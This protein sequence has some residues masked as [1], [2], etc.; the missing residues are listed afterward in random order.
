MAISHVHH[1]FRDKVQFFTGHHLDP[2][3]VVGITEI[4][5]GLVKAA[6]GFVERHSD[7]HGST[8][9][10]R[11]IGGVPYPLD[12]VFLGVALAVIVRQIA[13]EAFGVDAQATNAC[14]SSALPMAS[15]QPDPTTSS[16]SQENDASQEAV[17]TPTL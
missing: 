12:I 1:G 3:A 5:K 10:M 7:P 8:A 15:S 14:F 17:R 13:V 2:E 9:G 6:N 4:S 16:A 11:K